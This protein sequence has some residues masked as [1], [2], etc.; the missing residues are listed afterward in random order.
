[1]GNLL[2]IGVLLSAAVVLLG[3]IVYLMRYGGSPPHY[4]LFKGE[5]Q[6]LRTLSGTVSFAAHGHSRGIIQT[7]LLLLIATP[8]ARVVF[9]VYAFLRERDRLYVGV[10]LFVLAILTYS[11]VWGHL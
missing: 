4:R 5:P 7:G 9:S 10:T 6:D 3:G 11:I 2:R 8:I 1:M